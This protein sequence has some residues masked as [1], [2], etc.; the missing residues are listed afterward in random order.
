M[1]LQ[2]PFFQLF[3]YPVA[4][5]VVINRNDMLWRIHLVVVGALRF[6]PDQMPD[7]C[8]P[9]SLSHACFVIRGQI[10]GSFNRRFSTGNPVFLFHAQNRCFRRR[11][12]G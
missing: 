10:M 6:L 3:Q 7:I 12:S 11:P 4:E 8:R 1:F 9:F 5:P 2:L